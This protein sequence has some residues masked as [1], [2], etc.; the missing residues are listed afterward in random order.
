MRCYVTNPTKMLRL[1]TRYADWWNVSSTGVATYERMVRRF[2]EA[3]A[4]VGRVS[5]DNEADFGFV[6]T[7]QQIVT[8]SVIR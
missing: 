2:E 3:C 5:A 8:D 4:E 7:P 1:T 6:G